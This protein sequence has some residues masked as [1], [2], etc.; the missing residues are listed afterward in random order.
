MQLPRITIVIPFR[1][2]KDNKPNDILSKHELAFVKTVDGLFEKANNTIEVI[3]ALDGFWPETL[4]VDNPNLHYIHWGEAGGMRRGINAAA[5]IA[6]GEYLMKT[7]AHCLFAPGF[8]DALI[9]ASQP[10]WVQ[11][12]RRYSLDA[13]KWEKYKYP[14]DYM[15]LSWPDNPKDWGGAGFHGREWRERD[16]DPELQKI[17]L[18]DTMSFQG[19]CWF[20][21]LEYFNRL[22]L[23]DVAN[24]G[25]FW[26]EAQDIGLKCLFDGGRIIRNKRTWYAHLHKGR[27]YGRGFFIAKDSLQM[28]V[29][30]TKKL[31]KHSLDKFIPIIESQW[32][33]PG[34]PEDWKERLIDV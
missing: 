13:E 4:P 12:P 1:L 19:S 21:P 28:P 9:E 25:P 6:K 2:D 17:D 26:Q 27:Q 3:V 30:Y 24:Y 31:V 23:M 8:D 33:L 15:Y 11:I 32:P 16:K 18:D 10:N 22:G 14:R 7:D 34:W 29:E 20:M 5:D